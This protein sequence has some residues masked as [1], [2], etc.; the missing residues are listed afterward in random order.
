MRY[1]IHRWKL[2]SIPNCHD[3]C[4][5]VFIFT[6]YPYHCYYTHRACYF[7]LQCT[8]NFYRN[9]FCLPSPIQ[10]FLW[11]ECPHCDFRVWF[12]KREWRHSS[13]GIR[14]TKLS[15]TSRVVLA[16]WFQTNSYIYILAMRC[17]WLVDMIHDKKQQQHGCRWLVLVT[18]SKLRLAPGQMLF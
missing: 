10:S 4:A 17:N 11:Y 1:I 18:Q 15:L 16:H 3:H 9:Q 7:L 13:P 2:L 5:I 12:I 6:M 8:I 14:P